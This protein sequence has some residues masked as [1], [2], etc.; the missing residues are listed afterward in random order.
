MKVSRLGITCALV[1]CLVTSP[2]GGTVFAEEQATSTAE[3]FRPVALP[4]A[5]TPPFEA[6]ATRDAAGDRLRRSFHEFPRHAINEEQRG[7]RS[8]RGRGRGAAAA[9][10]MIG[11]AAAVAG[12]ALLVYA[13]RPEC[14]VNR[15]AGGCG[16]GTKVAGGSFLAGGAIGI[17]VGAALWR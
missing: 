16:Y 2:V 5:A 9:A 6:P 3:P 17:A 11:A 14:N 4:P 10:I 8:R 13:N 1:L 12:T 7:Y 15:S